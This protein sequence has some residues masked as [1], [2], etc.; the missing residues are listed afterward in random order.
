MNYD[1]VFQKARALAAQRAS[2]G[3]PV[4]QEDTVCVISSQSGR[5]YSGVNHVETVGGMKHNVHA[6]AE[7]IR[8]MQGGGEAVICSLVL[9]A[10][11]TGMPI[12]PCEH[13]LRSVLALHPE[14]IQSEIL[15][16]DRAVPINELIKDAEKYVRREQP[17]AAEETNTGAGVLM[18]HVNSLLNVADE[19][20]EDEEENK[21]GKTKKGFF[22]GLFK[23]KK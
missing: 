9:I 14:N 3:E 1:A 21:D 23:K 2:L 18:D 17:K 16:P 22:G 10:V 19:L 6:E 20:T 12:L 4:T 7:A 8:S 11:S 13:C 15:M 5:L